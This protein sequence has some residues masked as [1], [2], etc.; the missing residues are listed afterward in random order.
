MRLLYL[1]PKG[2][3]VIEAPRSNKRA[4]L[5]KGICKFM[6]YYDKTIQIVDRERVRVRSEAGNAEYAMHLA[7][8]VYMIAAS[9]PIARFDEMFAKLTP[10][11]IVAYRTLHAQIAADPKRWT[12]Q[13]Y[14][15]RRDALAKR[16]NPSKA[17]AGKAITK[18][19]QT[20]VMDLRTQ[21]MRIYN[22]NPIAAVA[23]AYAQVECNDFNTWDYEQ[24]YYGMVRSWP[25]KKPGATVVACGN[26]SALERAL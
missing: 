6:V 21:D 17:A 14:R 19:P 24:K 5:D 22:L 4:P 9:A 20:E 15:K 13:E 1:D 23:A 25:S 16:Y 3:H 12:W 26:Q 11:F 18:L 10:E 7:D 2:A 8:D